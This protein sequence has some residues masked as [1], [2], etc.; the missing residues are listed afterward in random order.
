MKK[1]KNTTHSTS[2]K[3]SAAS[4][5]AASKKSKSIEQSTNT[6]QL[7]TSSTSGRI[8]DSPTSTE[9]KHIEEDN[10]VCC[11]C[12]VSYEDDIQCNQGEEWFSVHMTSGYMQNVLIMTRCRKPQFREDKMSQTFFVISQL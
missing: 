12:N 1:L 3:R 10:A 9:E 11:K 8:A 6:D 5:K 4:A 7:C 2:R